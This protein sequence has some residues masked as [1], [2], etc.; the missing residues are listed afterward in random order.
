M[1]RCKLIAKNTPK[2]K[3]GESSREKDDVLDCDTLKLYFKEMARYALLTP[4]EEH[5]LGKTLSEL[6]QKSRKLARKIAR[7]QDPGYIS[8]KQIIRQDIEKIRNKFVQANLR[9]VINI[10]KRYC[11]KGLE[12]PD[13]ISEGNI[14]LFEAAMR[15]DYKR[16]C[17]FATYA[18]WW[19]RQAISKAL[20]YKG[21]LIR[22]PVQKGASLQRFFTVQ[23]VLAMSLGHE[24]TEIEL[25]EYLDWTLEKV[26]EL[27]QLLNQTCTSL[28]A[29]IYTSQE[30]GSFDL[31][32]SLPDEVYVRPEEA[33][34]SIDFTE[35]IHKYLNELS[36]KQRKVIEWRF[37]LN[38]KGQHTLKEIGEYFDCSSENVRHIEIK[39]L[40]KLRASKFVNR[41]RDY[42]ENNS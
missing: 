40:R 8:A 9:L 30:G 7:C 41:V 20:A 13:L 11:N 4:E 37:G 25:A 22:I 10:A 15:F 24:P 31:N 3:R 18:G 32:D 19:I 29:T 23:N 16:N 38:G 21:R 34:L 42:V 6:Q 36:D 26:Q 39:A 2:P 35:N 27:T 28:D 14:G 12:L 33:I 17:H 5:A 1:L